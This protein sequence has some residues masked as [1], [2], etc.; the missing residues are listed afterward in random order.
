MN[1]SKKKRSPR[2]RVFQSTDWRSKV[3][4]FL[5]RMLEHNKHVADLLASSNE[6]DRAE[7][8]RFLD[9][10][11]AEL[12]AEAERMH[13]AIPE[14]D[15]PRHDAHLSIYGAADSQTG[16]VIS[17][18]Q[19]TL[20]WLAWSRYGKTIQELVAG[21]KAGHEKSSKQL[22]SV[23]KDYNDWRYGK[24]DPNKLR[25]KFD[26]NHLT[27]MRCG[28]D[29]GMETLNE[30]DLANCFDE[31]CTCGATHDG[32]K[33]RKLRARTTKMIK[34]LQKALSLPLS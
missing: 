17:E 7:G 13:D 14:S 23:T 32:E 27:V 16:T 26:Y 33:L 10:P 8:Q 9:N 15:R 29:L 11:P 12:M 18:D 3:H 22:A 5:V 21:D 1:T 25:S 19:F 2:T 4:P 30:E 34:R 31:T 20:C 6:A 24:L 28:L